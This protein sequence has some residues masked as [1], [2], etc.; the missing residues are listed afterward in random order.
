MSG[1]AARLIAAAGRGD[2]GAVS[3]ALR[4]RSARVNMAD[5]H[6][7]QAVH[8]A[9]LAGHCQVLSQLLA[10]RASVEAVSQR[11]QPLHAA[12]AGGQLKAAALLLEHHADLDAPEAGGLRPLHLAALGGKSEMVKALVSHRAQ[13]DARNNDDS[14]AL[15][16]AANAGHGAMIATLLDLGTS[17]EESAK[18]GMRA[19]HFAAHAGREEATM[20]LL[21]RGAHIDART[22]DGFD[23]EPLHLAARGGHAKVAALLLDRG[24]R[25]DARAKHGLL[26]VAL[27]TTGKHEECAQLL[28]DA[29]AIDAACVEARQERDRCMDV[30]AM[31]HL[32]RAM[33]LCA[34][35]QLPRRAAE[36]AVE[37]SLTEFRLGHWEECARLCRQVLAAKPPVAGTA[38]VKDRFR[39]ALQN[40]K[41]P[42]AQLPPMRA[43]A[44][45]HGLA[46]RDSE[47]E[48]GGAAGT[49]D[50]A[51]DFLAPG[52]LSPSLMVE[53]LRRRVSALETERDDALAAL[54]EQAAEHAAELAAAREEAAE[55]RQRC[56]RLEAERDATAI[57]GV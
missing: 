13:L 7:W 49:A 3:T 20:L 19:L 40:I 11:G 39:E 31:P 56:E 9:A 57:K 18:C 10:A 36:I 22:G 25:L 2:A 5:E 48:P 1:N 32:T 47:V 29:G 8:E 54:E 43:V 42:P 55:L 35:L 24:A 34:Q 16:L 38:D 41:D 6:G 27:A 4:P 37:A 52:D 17:A 12:A 33:E 44:P 46:A 14:Q 28:R 23:L 30:L 45:S 21:D 26:P 51:A 50:S 53:C 15:H